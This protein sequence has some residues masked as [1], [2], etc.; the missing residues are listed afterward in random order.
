MEW[1]ESVDE[2]LAGDLA[3]GLAYLTPARG[4]VITPMAPLGLRDREAGTVT[5]ST[6]LG[7]WKKLERIRANP[8]VAVAFHARDHADSDRPEFVLVQGEAT[9]QSA[10]DRAWLDSIGPQWEHFLG[11]RK[12]GLLGRWQHVYYY[13]RVAITVA[14]RRILVWPTLDCAGEPVVHG[15]PLP[16]PPAPQS[17]PKNGT[18][19]RT[20]AARLAA[21]V[22]RLPH[23]LLGW[24]G[25]D[26]LPMVT[27]VSAT[28]AGPGGAELI[29]PASV[30]PEGGRRAGLTAHRFEP[31]MVGQEQR[32][33]TGWLEVDGDRA[34]YAPHTRAGYRLPA[35][36]ALMMLGSGAST[37][38]GLRKARERGQA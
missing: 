3:A 15:E 5:L 25:G 8:G 29:V 30:R 32:V 26:G 37:R 12:E 16:D 10:P 28:G 35:S 38:L 18:G 17:P 34:T 11:K 33:Y 14:V 2:V 9:V 31:R 6:S 20:D 21:E 13:E 7:L 19:P 27:A 22:G 4:V 1:P 23:S 24:A 36:N